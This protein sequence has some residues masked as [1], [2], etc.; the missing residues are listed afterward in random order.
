[1]WEARRG[2]IFGATAFSSYGAFWIS[3]GLFGILS[4]VSFLLRGHGVPVP[5]KQL[6]HAVS[7]AHNALQY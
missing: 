3:F 2:K 4:S 6:L 1:M 5:R 7:T